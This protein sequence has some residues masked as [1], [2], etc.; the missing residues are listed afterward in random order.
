[1]SMQHMTPA[2]ITTDTDGS[3]FLGFMFVLAF[4]AVIGLTIAAFIAA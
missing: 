4:Y 1:M 3:A 2:P